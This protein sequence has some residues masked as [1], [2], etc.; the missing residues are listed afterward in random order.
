MTKPYVIKKTAEAKAQEIRL[1]SKAISECPKQ[2]AEAKYENG[3]ISITGGRKIDTEIDTRTSNRLAYQET[4]RQQNIESVIANAAQEL[5]TETPIPESKPEPE[6]VS[7]FVDISA[8]ISSDEMQ[9]LWGKILAGEI[10][11]PGS[12]SLRT[13]ETLRNITKPEAEVFSKLANCIISANGDSF[14]INDNEHL[15]KTQGISFA[16][17]LSLKD[18]GLIHESSLAFLIKPSKTEPKTVMRCGGKVIFVERKTAT[19][20]AE[21]Q[22]NVLTKV[23]RELLKLT[24]SSCSDEYLKLICK[25][26]NQK[27]LIMSVADIT[28][29]DDSG[30]HYNPQSLQIIQ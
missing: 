7:R 30:I 27:D 11:Q 15:I 20:K 29:E 10:K 23:G 24:S 4:I 9:Q 18:A 25:K 21:I 1:I 6:W 13:L 26:I 3:E 12:Y 8:S 17:I 22:I 5:T 19:A 2:I 16:Q 28:K 14:Y